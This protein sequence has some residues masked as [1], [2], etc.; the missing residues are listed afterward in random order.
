MSAGSVCVYI[1]AADGTVT[2]SKTVPDTKKVLSML[3]GAIEKF[4]LKEGPALVKPAPQSARPPAGPD[5]LALHLSAPYDVRQGSWQGFPAETWLVLEKAEWL[6]LLPAGP[7]ESGASWDIDPEVATRLLNHFYPATED[8][9]GDQIDRNQIE[10][11]SL[12]ATV[13]SVRE[14]RTRARID[15]VFSMKRP[16]YPGHP[17]HKPVQIDATIVGL[18]EF[19]RSAPPSLRLV[20]ETATFNKAKFGVALRSVP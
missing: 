9:R 1:V 19:D 6:M 18:L 15:G 11:A 13:E 3:E 12:K 7:R 4:Q 5:A 14:G 20:T 10:T 16:F 2:D 17:E 8:T